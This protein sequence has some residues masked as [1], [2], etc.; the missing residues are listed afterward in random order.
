[1]FRH[2]FKHSPPEYIGQHGRSISFVFAEDGTR[3]TQSIVLHVTD[4]FD[5]ERLDSECAELHNARFR[6]G[7]SFDQ[8]GKA[9]D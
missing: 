7:A 6:D 9:C 2:V 4:A 3:Q 8:L 1:M 5:K